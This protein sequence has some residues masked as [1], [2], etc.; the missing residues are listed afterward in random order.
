MSCDP[1][2]LKDW[3]LIN[4]RILRNTIRSIVPYPTRRTKYERVTTVD[5]L[6]QLTLIN[7]WRY[8]HSIPAEAD[9]QHRINWACKIAR[10][11]TITWQRNTLRDIQH[12]EPNTDY[13]QAAL[14][15]T[16]DPTADQATD[17]ISQLSADDTLAPL[18]AQ[19]K[20]IFKLRLD[21]YTTIEIAQ[22]LHITPAAARQRLVRARAALR[23]HLRESH[24]TTEGIAQHHEPTRHTTSSSNSAIRGSLRD[25]AA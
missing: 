19:L 16:P 6:L 5:D 24:N 18:P 9:A 7:I 1:Q 2:V 21:G 25:N 20:Q 11:I 17:T 4:E 14:D 22:R 10:N 3:V 8:W 13:A 15:N 12:I 23:E